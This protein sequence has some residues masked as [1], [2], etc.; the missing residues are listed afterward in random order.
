MHHKADVFEPFARAKQRG[1][2]D[3][4][5]TAQH[6]GFVCANSTLFDDVRGCLPQAHLDFQPAKSFARRTYSGQKTTPKRQART[7]LIAPPP[8]EP[9]LLGYARRSVRPTSTRTQTGLSPAARPRFGCFPQT[10]MYGSHR[11]PCTN[12]SPASR[13]PQPHRVPAKLPEIPL[14]A[15]KHRPSQ[16]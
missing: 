5:V 6:N 2:I 16:P 9:E 4:F 7:T 12:H 1:I 10:I 14:Q 13:S 3:L 11:H 15:R 8:G